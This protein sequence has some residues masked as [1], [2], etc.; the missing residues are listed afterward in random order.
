M[1][2]SFV[3]ISHLLDRASPLFCFAVVFHAAQPINDN[4]LCYSSN[5]DKFGQTWIENLLFK[6]RYASMHS[7]GLMFSKSGMIV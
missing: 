4:I 3:E 2:Y 1:T 7:F 5:K 6:Y